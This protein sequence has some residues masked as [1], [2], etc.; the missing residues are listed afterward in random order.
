MIT[1][2]RVMRDQR[3]R[4]LEALRDYTCGV[5]DHP[6]AAGPEI[7]ISVIDTPEQE[8]SALLEARG[9]AVLAIRERADAYPPLPTESVTDYSALAG[10]SCTAV[11]A[12][13]I[14]ILVFS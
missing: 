13:V 6:P 1:D 8:V 5:D 11:L 14:L 9:V 12:V 10:W 7:E 3:A 2:V 4:A